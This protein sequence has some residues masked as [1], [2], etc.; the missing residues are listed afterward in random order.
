MF[1][2][3]TSISAT[4]K[5]RKLDWQ[6]VVTL[7]GGLI[8]FVYALSEGNNAG[9]FLSLHFLAS[10][11]EYQIRLD[12]TTDYYHPYLVGHICG[13]V[14]LRRAL[15]QGPR[16]T[17]KNVVEPELFAIVSLFLE[18]GLDILYRHPRLIFSKC[19]L[20][21]EWLRAPAH[22]NISSLSLV[23]FLLCGN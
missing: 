11:Y 1:L 14:L 22:T 6:G 9:S 12:K 4:N 20:V 17:S 16:G 21:S 23:F 15:C 8:L 2:P 7:A 3:N 10:I 13:W 18:V 19:L 5:Q